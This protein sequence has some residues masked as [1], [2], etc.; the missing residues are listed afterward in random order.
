MPTARVLRWISTPI[1]SSCPVRVGLQLLVERRQHRGRALQQDDPRLAG[2]DRPVVARQHGVRQ[3][4]D[5]P[6]RL[7]TGRAGADH[8]ERQPLG[9]LGRVGRQL[10]HLERRQDPVAQ[11]PGV[12]DGLHAGRELGELVAAEVGVR[13]AGRDDQRVVAQVERPA[14]GRLGADLALLEVDVRHLGEQR[15]GVGLLLDDAAQRR[16]D[17][18]GRQDPGRHLVE[19]R[20]EQVVVR[21]VHQ[22]HVDVG[23]GELPGGV[24]PAEPAADHHHA[25]SRARGGNGARRSGLLGH[26]TL[27]VSSDSTSDNNHVRRT[28]TPNRPQTPAGRHTKTP[29]GRRAR[30]RTPPHLVVGEVGEDLRH[31]EVPLRRRRDGREQLGGEL[32]DR[33]LARLHHLADLRQPPQLVPRDGSGSAGAVA[34]RRPVAGQH[35]LRA[36]HGDPVQR[37]RGRT[38]SG[39]SRSRAR[40]SPAATPTAAGG[41]PSTAAGPRRSTGRCGRASG[42]GCARPPTSGRRR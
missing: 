37:L 21:P 18:P 39:R 40:R 42:P 30:A 27:P 3:L 36:E 4:R 33:A 14:V 32:G 7:H 29:S 1:F 6:D 22:R 28:R 16:R 26:G 38:P 31:R 5:L 2:V 35:E 12:L 10:G 19:Q 9:P 24:Q 15:A 20:L 25:V 23:V 13:G 17:Q 8:H 34:E 41:R 11:V